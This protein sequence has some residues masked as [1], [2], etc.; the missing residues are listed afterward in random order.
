MNKFKRL[1]LL[2]AIL[3]FLMGI[4]YAVEL[5]ISK[6][7][8]LAERTVGK[9]RA[10]VIAK[11]CL[12]GGVV[13]LYTSEAA[14]FEWQKDGSNIG[15]TSNTCK[16]TSSGTYRIVKDSEISNEITLN[17]DAPT[18]SFSH[19]A[20]NNAC[21]TETVTFTNTSTNGESYLWEFGDGQTS[22]AQNPTHTF[23]A[24]LGGGKQDFQVK[25]TVTNSVCQSTSNIQVV[26]VKKLP[27]VSVADVNVFNAFSNC[28]NNPTNSNPNYTLSINNT[29]TDKTS[30]ANYTI[31]WGDGNIQTGI[32]NASFPLSH[33]YTRLDAF[34][35]KV[36]AYGSNGC[37]NTFTQTVANQS[38]PAGSLGTDGGTTNL[39]APAK[40]PFVISNWK[41]NSPGTT[42]VLEYGDGSSETFIHPLNSTGQDFRVEH[43]YT[44]SSCPERTF[45][46]RLLVKNACDI[47]PYTAGNI[48]INIKPVAD[49][50]VDS[51]IICLGN[52]VRFTDRTQKGAYGNCSNLTVYSWD[53]GDGNTSSAENPTHTYAAAG[54]Y[55]VK[56]K[57]SNP[58]GDTEKTEKI[59]V[60]PKPIA[61]FT[62]PATATC[63]PY[64]LRPTNTSNSP[65]PNCG[66]NT[67]T[68]Q[69]TRTG[70]TADCD[71]FGS[72]TTQTSTLENPTF[73]LT[74][75]G[76]YSLA[77][78]TTN[79]S[80]TGCSVISAPQTITV[81]APPT[82]AISSTIPATICEGASINPTAT[83]KNCWG[84][85][86]VSYEWEFPGAITASSASA[87]PTNIVYPTKGNYQIRLKVSNECGSSTIYTKNIT[88]NEK[89][90]L[91]TIADIVVCKGAFI[92]ATAFSTSTSSAASYTWTNSNTAIGLA[93][94]GNSSSLPAFTATNTGT[95]PIT[96]TITVTP[97]ATGGNSCTGEAKTFTITVNPA[98]AAA[99][100][101]ADFSL[102][103]VTSTQL[104]AAVAPTGGV[105]SVVSGTS[106]LTFDDATNPTATIT[107]LVNGGTYLL[108]WTVQGYAPCGNSEDT[109]T[110]TVSPETVAGT[111]SGATT[112][113]GTSTA[114][115]VTLSGHVG[116]ILRWEQSANGTTWSNV[117]PLNQTPTLNYNSLTA[118]TH[119]RAVVKSG[120]CN[121]LYSS[122]TKIEI[123]AK[124]AAPL[125]TANYIYCLNDVPTALTATGT[126][127]KWYS[128]LPISSANLLAG[129]PTP[130]TSVA[131]TLTYYVTQS[132]NGCES[133]YTA[134]SVKINPTITNNIASA[135]QTICINGTPSLLTGQLPSGGS[136]AYSYQWE[137]STDNV[138]FVP[139]VGATGRN[140]QP[141]ALAVTTYYRRIVSSGSCNSTS[142]QIAVTVQ[143]TLANTDINANQ[144]IC[145]NSI[146][147]QLTG[148][149][150]TGGSG[151]FTY[152]WEAS[153]NPSTNGFS[154]IIG[155]TGADYQPG[156]LTQTTYFRRKVN[157]GSC[158]AI[159][160]AV[161]IT[162]IPQF[163]VVQKQNLVSC[164]QAVQNSIVFTTDFSSANISYAWE[165]DNPS[166]GLS[167][168]GTGS[169]PAFTANNT[170]KAP[171]VA[172]ISYKAI[173]TEAPLTCDAT[174]KAFTFTILPTINVTTALNDRTLCTGQTTTAVSLTSDAVAF[175]GAT[176]KY[177]WSSDEA[178]GLSNGEGLAIPSF[179]TINNGSNPITSEIT[180]VPIYTYAGKTC[181][182][183]PK[184]YRITVNPA[185]RIDFSL[186]N[187]TI[188]SN[189]TTAAVDLSSITAN[190]DLAWTAQTV[191]G[192]VGM[193]TSGTNQIPTQTLINNTSAPITII[194][195][196]KAITR[197]DANC[198]GVETEYRI[199]VNPI[200]TLTANQINQTICSNQ[201][202]NIILGSNVLGTQYSWSVSANPNVTGVSSGT[203]ASIIQNLINTSAIPQTVTYTVVPTF[204]NALVACHGDALA[205]EITVN[206]SPVVSFSGG[207]LSICSGKTSPAVTL[208]SSTPN[209]QITWTANVPV[210]ITGVATLSGTN[211]IPTETLVNNANV[212]LTII[213]TASAKTDDTKACAG[214]TATYRVTV[215]PVAR[216]INTNLA[217][218]VCAGGRNTAVIF[219][220][221]VANAT[222][223]WTA[224]ASSN[225]LTG[226][227][228]SGNGAIPV[229]TLM[230][231]STQVQKI[232]YTVKPIAYGCEGQ[233]A[234]YEIDV[235]PSPM[236]TSSTLATEICSGKTFRYTPVSSTSGVTFKWTRAAILGISNA[237]ASGIGI[238]V[239]GSISEALINT[240]VNP[241]DVV[242]EYEMSINGCT[243]GNKIP[244]V[245]T[246][247]PQTTANFGLSAI[248]GCAPFNLVISNLNS[249]ALVSTYAVDFGDGSAIETYNDTRDITHTYQN[250]TNQPKIFYIT[251]TTRNECGESISRPYQIRV[252]PQSVFSKL[253][254]DATQTFGCA[255]LVVNFT[256]ANQS[257]GANLYTWDFGDGSPTRQTKSVNE[258]L[259]HT[260]STPGAY[261]V[262]LTATN[263][264]STISTTEEITVYPQVIANFNV[265]Q[266]QDCVGAEFTF[267]NL[268]GSQFTS[269]WDFGDGTTS[270]EVNP[271]HSYTT[272][273]VKI[274]T[275]R[276]TQVYPNGGSCTAIISKT[277]NVLAAPSATFTTNA[278]TLNCG[279]FV[280]R[281]NATGN[282]V[283]NVEWDFGDGSRATGIN[284]NHTFV[285]VGDYTVTAKAYNA[286]GCTNTSSQVVRVSESPAA[287]FNPSITEI[288]GTTGNASFSNQTTYGGTD[289]VT[290]KWW[291]NGVLVSNQR[292][293]THHFVVPDGAS[294]PYQFKIKLE[295]SN[296][297]GCT[298]SEEKILQ[299]NPFSTAIFSVAQIKGCA[300]FKLIVNNQSTYADIFEWYLDGRLVSTERDP[301]NIILTDFDKRYQLK[302][303]VKNRY[304]CA[305]SEQVLEVATHPYL[306]AL[307]T[308]G[309]DLSCN[310]ILDVQIIN[311]SIGATTYTWDYGDGTPVYIGINPVHSYGRPG[312]Y[313]LKL[314]VSNG[315]CSDTQIKEVRVSNAPRA[316][317][318][319]DV[320]NGCNQL[321]VRFRN[322]S[323]NA[324]SYYWD[325]G[326][327][328]FSREENPVHQYIYSSTA[329]TVKLIASNA[330]GCTDETVVKQAISVFPPPQANIE[331][332][333]NKIIKVPDYSFTFKA[334]STEQIISYRWEFGDGTTADRKE[335]THKYDRFG[336]YKVKLH[337]TNGSNCVNTIE[338][339]V[340]IIDFPGYLYIPNAFEPENLNND[341][342]VFKVKA[343]GL[344]TYHLKIFNKWGQLIW[345]TNKL[346][347]DGVP[348]EYWDGMN[349]DT[350]L[351]LGAYYWQ[352]EATYINGGVWKGMKY[353]NKAETKTGVIHLIR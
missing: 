4:S 342:K 204:E 322:T 336:T 71:N 165:N 262:T 349:G 6:N 108:K 325:F 218:T 15:V 73:N 41:D 190:V 143:G 226:F 266:P 324:T 269:V 183:T 326:D 24:S 246:V 229:Q 28:H 21:G 163:N 139:I 83:V 220:S 192:I 213:Y 182:G 327:G 332:T 178:I 296:M 189:S 29:S 308:L 39:C 299:F 265:N 129:A 58:C 127:L 84:T 169:L 278:G 141:S 2:F 237:A 45:T 120:S 216:L 23:T 26:S 137:S 170:T 80:G 138:N 231:S 214:S 110:I 264:C 133:N 72:F 228:T 263:G 145:Y 125:A 38:N 257:T 277:V 16:P 50:T 62:L 304:G 91:N 280:L 186:P 87:N 86:P 95:A 261:R 334:T 313:Q 303:I 82:A 346:D 268:S 130:V 250:G 116:S 99:N 292:D 191:A 149:V 300:P 260:Y 37:V 44:R 51:R 168:S 25:L 55:T 85:D 353:G 209:S 329:Y 330:F 13:E 205:I 135:D 239:A 274:I 33:T 290:Y 202:T 348:I 276:A 112:Y 142:N 283:V 350:L 181:E 234:T 206:P 248:N 63:A 294:L 235:Y 177:R 305:A 270:T 7:K 259:S 344:A 242:Y 201:S 224:T 173:Y 31:D 195:K 89:P 188:C 11:R 258:N 279:P 339:E 233:T 70:S 113:C 67:Y 295:A 309:N 56:L 1:S 111:T 208:S 64:T 335:I 217:Q 160:N 40:V 306:K 172:N 238:D 34:Q 128:A 32:N 198:E 151:S 320:N 215:N 171:L 96:A 157:S 47:T 343:S 293:L 286:Q 117:S 225:Q 316:A 36:T 131:T 302:L 199:T 134:I 144:T 222:F 245:V 167:A 90:V 148:Q 284:V 240:T 146:P 53:F 136:G 254:L 328:S 59:C 46:A 76:V 42:Y 94:S 102:C 17:F 285:R 249:R 154:N 193:A 52:S 18:A 147:S 65:L 185:A 281:A 153:T 150:P 98:V 115:T 200:P 267:T 351:P 331:I 74:Q 196:A 61:S 318:L 315:F 288:C 100:A 253:V 156:N 162:V 251:I 203:G 287:A 197:G 210:G 69:L 341:L 103:N 321:S 244:L 81:K 317:F 30:I 126:D 345:Q 122:P 14:P 43:T 60:N 48:Q 166:I 8:V 132:V 212:P 101:G 298:T 54:E 337:I 180:V 9:N 272:S 12:A 323:V 252:Q 66:N 164:N 155:A 301:D 314:T 93:T 236:F 291:V 119:Y 79:A 230:N 158:S 194:Y 347:Q 310:G 140:Y 107:G 255:P 92:P 3:L 179:T 106:A 338:D 27:R 207:D 123:L 271:K 78:T 311:N 10:L 312:A 105:W 333:P 20:T 75:P 57:T 289:V 275:L 49:F 174:P 176:V 22:T 118:T 352:A 297:V 273:G 184:S 241:I 77:L 175:V 121:M 159:S 256:A 187:Q 319:T 282:N 243:S 247:N 221:N 223:S 307:F 211:T 19:N 152:Q 109:M 232:T 227:T 68:W 340:T 104:S 124:P 97:R 88:V 161:T 219:Q 114:G 5:Q 35:L